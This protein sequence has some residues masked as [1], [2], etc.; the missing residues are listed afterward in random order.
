[1]LRKL[2][3]LTALGL[4]LLIAAGAQAQNVLFDYWMDCGGGTAVS[5]LTSLGSYP[6]G[7]TSSEYRDA[8]KSKVDWADNYGERARSYL[9]PPADGDYTFWIAGDDACQLWLSTDD[10]AANAKM[11]AQVT[12]WT[13]ADDWLNTGGG[14]GGPEQKSALQSL[15]AGQK[16]YIEALHK[17]GGGGDSV[18]VAWGG[19]TIGD[20]PVLIAAEFFAKFVETRHPAYSPV[21]ANGSV[22]VTDP[23]ITWTAGKT[24]ATHNLYFG[25]N[26]APGAAE[27]KGQQ[28]YAMYFEIMG[29]VPGATYYWRVDEVEKDGTTIHT[30]D[31]WT[32]T[33]QPL[34]AHF[35]S[36]ANG[37]LLKGTGA[38]PTLSWT[39]GQSVL[40][41]DVYFGTDQAKVA[42]GDAAV[43]VSKAQA[44][45]TFDPGALEA[46]TTYYWR[47][48]EHDSAGAVQ[49]GAVWSL[50]ITD[51]ASDM[52]TDNWAVG[53]STAQPKYLNTY[54]ADG[55]YDI[56]AFGDEM[57]YEFVVRSNPAEVEAS[58]CLIGRRDFGATQM[59]LKYEQW[60][61]TKT[62]GATV[63]GV[64]DYDFG[65]PTAPGEYTH[66]AFVASK[67]AG[68]TDL[69]VNGILKGS[70]ATA[71]TLSGSV[72]IGY[73][74]QNRPPAAPFFDNFDG[75]IFGVAI[76]DRLL[77]ASEIAANADKY[78]NPIAITDPDL[79]LYYD[80]ES[81]SG[82]MAVD[83]SGHSNHGLFMGSPKWATGVLGGCVSIDIATLD[84]IQTAVP[85]NIVSNTVSVTGWVKH[86]KAPAAWSGI[87]THRGTSPG[88]VGLQH[89]GT[90]LRYMWGADEYWSF[91]SGLKIPNGEWYF[92]ALTISPTQGKL[93]L[94]GVGQTATN[95][96]PH[97]PTNFDSLIR[98]G[99]DHQDSRIMTSLIDEVRFY[100]KTLTDTDIQRLV[101][102]DVTAP[103]DAVQ[104]VP[105]DGDWPGAEYPALAIDNNANTK[106][107]HFKGELLPTGIQVTPAVGATIV[108]GLTFTTAN[109]SPGRDPVKFELS[110][111]DDSIDGP[112]TVIAT[113]DIVDFAQ[114]DAWPRFTMNATAISFDNAVAYKHYQIVF[115]A[116]RNPVTDPMMQ[117]AEVEL[118]GVVAEP[119]NLL[120]NGGFESGVIAPY[121]TYGTCTTEV[122]TD[123][124]GATVAQ[125]PVEGTY[126]LHVVVPAA[127]ANSWDV[128]MT[129]SSQVFQAGKNYKFSAWIKCKSGTLEF[130]M[131][132]ERSAD[133]W[134]GYNELVATATDTWQEFS[135]TTGVIPAEVKPASPT[136]HIGFAAGDFWIDNVKLQ[137][138]P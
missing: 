86:D 68:T 61:N 110:G 72:G 47:V 22:D 59:G 100:N 8:L 27:F 123:C 138:V 24:A 58:M 133:P 23:L 40:S 119:A 39:A 64:A 96:A 71:I 122:V 7:P 87:L 129:D 95:V 106:F 42:A 50:R 137:E 26:P 1:M 20:G 12:G 124:V 85:L 69:Y 65:V 130:R 55:V 44:G 57:T 13:P 28:S 79:L 18:S 56:G 3:G 104:G 114:A 37:V 45:T 132:P 90:E 136:F 102:S 77:S 108:R 73:G 80:F 35:P 112:W 82:T 99:R 46:L 4:V 103:G 118:L 48:D 10:T 34:T 5:D 125:G 16:Y 88:N 29:L 105:N 53:V 93:Y 135:T 60:N 51:K 14:A 117:I 31:V 107:L 33:V 131:K 89:D 128:G 127:G 94:N 15:K 92:A 43:A 134:E 38:A 109:D 54:V 76:Y 30:G 19:P 9:V 121:G 91:S 101:L 11:I 25:T 66:L 6:W 98:V 49:A 78:F 111:S 52:N 115:P 74:A 75:D 17:E 81:G 41:H 70:V 32:F 116:L 67:A 126:C 120:A 83:Q 2:V 84:Y 97:Q 21:P 62:Y 63:F 113:G 36:P